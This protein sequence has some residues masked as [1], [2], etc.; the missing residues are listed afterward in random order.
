MEPGFW[1]VIPAQVRYAP[2]IPAGAKL[3]YAEIS[4]LTDKHGYCYA[5]NAYFQELYGIS[6]ATV[7]RYLRALKNGGFIR[8]QDGD[9]G[10]GRRKIYAGINPLTENPLK[11]DGVPEDPVKNDGVTPSKKTPPLNNDNNKKLNKDPLPPKEKPPM[12]E[13]LIARVEHYAGED[14]Q[15]RD[16]LLEFAKMRAARKKDVKTERQLTL[17][18]SKL[19]ELSGGRR[20]EK[21]AIIDKATV[22]GWLSFYPL[23]EDDLD[24]PP[25]GPPDGRSVASPK[26][27]RW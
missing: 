25:H 1:A 27:A 18:L 4:S 19:N 2:E 5:S 6:E 24:L 9:G 8:I 7:Q 22:N 13:A 14:L 20:R 12:P 15:I 16:A 11:N 21:L 10:A 3:L 17:L 23:H 26:V